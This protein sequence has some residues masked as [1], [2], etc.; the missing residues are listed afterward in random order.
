MANE[1]L[2]HEPTS[3]QWFSESQFE[4]YR[5][6]GEHLATRLGKSSGYEDG[7]LAGFFRDIKDDRAP[8]ASATAGAARGGLSFVQEI[9]PG[10][11]VSLRNCSVSNR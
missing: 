11:P 6:L 8:T 1:A 3:N 2:P 4:S 7:G 9:A 5:A 10:R